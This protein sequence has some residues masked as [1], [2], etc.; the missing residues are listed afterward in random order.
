M[1]LRL[2]YML[3]SLLGVALSLSVAAY[4]WR[5]RRGP[6]W[7]WL[8]GLGLTVAWWCAGQGFYYVMNDASWRDLLGQLQYLGIATT[9]VA[10][11]GVAMAATGRKAWAT[12][13][14]LA[15][16]LAVPA[17]TIAMVLTNEAHH[18]FWR[19]Y[20]SMTG[21]VLKPVIV[22]GPLFRIHTVY[23]YGLCVLGVIFLASRFAA[24]PHYRASLVAVI[25]GPATVA[26]GNVLQL[27]GHNPLPVDPTPASFAIAFAFIGWAVLRHRL[28]ELTPMARGVAIESLRDGIIAVDDRGR[29]VDLNPAARRLLGEK[30]TEALGR[31]LGELLELPAELAN[32]S[33]LTVAGGRRVEVH[34]SQLQGEEA[35]G[36]SVVVLRDVTV[37]REAQ[38]ALLRA[39]SELQAANAELARLART[40]ALTGLANRRHLEERFAEELARARRHRRPLALLLVD[41]DHFKRLNDEHGHLVG[42]GVLAAVGRELQ[43]LARAADV[44][45]RYGG[46]ELAMLLPETDHEGAAEAGRRAWSAL[47]ELVHRGPQGTTLRVTASVGAAA[48]ASSDTSL[49]DLVARADGAL[50]HAKAAGRD[51]VMLAEGGG[52]LAVVSGEAGVPV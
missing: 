19:S 40:D 41:L 23:S 28:L 2:S 38:E 35:A 46:E 43:R 20:Q 29:A 33:L 12:A 44:A 8:V 13:K 1:L 34:R 52:F 48:L 49:S 6:A 10:W 16:L 4:A 31:P 18:L 5:R 9:P 39:Q 51:R 21:G 25:A 7:P 50:Y 15:A 11:F 22:Y 14:A 45:A 17:F 36:G 27:S 37:E 42:D 30:A 24:S 32:G 3:P 47:R 26:A